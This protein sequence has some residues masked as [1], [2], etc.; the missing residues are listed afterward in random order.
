LQF[1]LDQSNSNQ[2]LDT[3][4]NACEI[5]IGQSQQILDVINETTYLHHSANSSSVGAHIRHIIERF[6]CFF[7][8]YQIKQINYDNRK[9]DRHLET[10][11]ASARSVLSG[12]AQL[13]SQVR[14]TEIAALSVTES[15]DTNQAP[16]LVESTVKRELMGLVSHTTHHL[17]IIVLLVNEQGGH[18]PSELGKAASTLI[19]EQN[20]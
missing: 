10:N 1:A 8:G 3:L 20:H 16:V 15:V 14:N 11:L 2:P 17:A 6:N 9:R 5:C 13:L 18:L 19:Y 4:T 12:F 7:D